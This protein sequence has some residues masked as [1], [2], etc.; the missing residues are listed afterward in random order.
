MDNVVNFTVA[1]QIKEQQKLDELI[2]EHLSDEEDAA[3]VSTV[4]AMEIVD[5][6][7]HLGY[8]ISET[9]ECIKDILALIESI[10]AI[11]Y[12]SK[13]LETPIHDVNNT[14]YGW[15]EDEADLLDKFLSDM[16]DSLD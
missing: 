4:A 3:E 7:I 14:L 16:E 9:P 15:V 2:E 6:L 8:P 12:R 13:G 5:A 1:K 10:R 11:A